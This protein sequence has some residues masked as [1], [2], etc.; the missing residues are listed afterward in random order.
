MHKI[1]QTGKKRDVLIVYLFNIFI[2]SLQKNQQKCSYQ[3]YP[4]NNSEIIHQYQLH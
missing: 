1:Q 4:S 2:L 3:I